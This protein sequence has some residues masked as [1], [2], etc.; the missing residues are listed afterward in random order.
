MTYATQAT[1]TLPPR[2]KGS[3]SRTPDYAPIEFTIPKPATNKPKDVLLFGVGIDDF[4]GDPGANDWSYNVWKGMFDRCYNEKSTR[5]RATYT[6]CLVAPCWHR[7]SDFKVW[8]D[9]NC[10]D[11]YQLD[12]D[13]LKPGNR[14]YSPDT[15]CFVP[16]YINQAARWWRKTPKSGYPGVRIFGGGLQAEITHK[17]SLKIGEFRTDALDAHC[18]WQRLKA[19]AIDDHLRDYLRETAPDLRVVRA[20]IKYADLLRSNA[21]A[22]IPTFQYRH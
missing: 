19:D 6:D 13:I 21:D 16:Q 12:K 18:D 14:V 5:S 8:F 17:S 15:C 2:G 11:G 1:E 20:L 7:Y 4:T 10:I 3:R 22:L 9:K